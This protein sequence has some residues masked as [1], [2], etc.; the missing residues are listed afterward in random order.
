M[1]GGIVVIGFALMLAAC[2]QPSRSDLAN[3][4]RDQYHSMYDKSNKAAD[5][6]GACNNDLSC[7]RSTFHDTEAAVDS[8]NQWVSQT[9]FPSDVKSD[10]DALVSAN[11]RVLAAVQAMAVVSDVY[12]AQTLLVQSADASSTQMSSVQTLGDDLLKGS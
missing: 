2:G 7:I 11:E 12:T 5:A 1:R 9:N 8:F 3:Q 6:A 4:L 10:V